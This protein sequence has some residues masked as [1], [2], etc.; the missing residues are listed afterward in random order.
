[1]QR[2]HEDAASLLAGTTGTPT[3]MGVVLDIGG[4]IRMDDHADSRNVDAAGRHVS[5]DE[6]L[7]LT[8]TEGIESAGSLR[9]SQFPAE[10]RGGKTLGGQAF[11]QIGGVHSTADKD[12]HPF[13]LGVEQH[14]GQSAFQFTGAD[15]M[16]NVLDIRVGFPETGT[17]DDERVLLKTIGEF[18]H[19]LREG[20]GDQ[21]AVAFLGQVFEDGFQ[22]FTES[23]VEHLVRFIE[24]HLADGTAAQV[25]GSNVIEETAG[26]TDQ[27]RRRFF[28]GAFLTDRIRSAGHHFDGDSGNL[29][30]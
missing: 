19:R 17:L 21:M 6:N 11:R 27:H 14:V 25:T 9:L 10:R 26:G 2:H 29:R 5:G 20:R 3:A 1:M 13:S 16:G 15:Q 24:D 4:D 28:Q 12:Q 23:H 30:Q 7:L 8:M 22:L 18:L